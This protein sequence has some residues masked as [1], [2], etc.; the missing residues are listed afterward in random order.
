MASVVSLSLLPLILL[1]GKN[2]IFVDFCIEKTLQDELI[3][4]GYEFIGKY[5]KGSKGLGLIGSCVGA[6][7]MMCIGHDTY[8][9][10]LPF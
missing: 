4:S 2:P 9:D 3:K 8:I 1:G 7:Y 5:L 6:T 10:M